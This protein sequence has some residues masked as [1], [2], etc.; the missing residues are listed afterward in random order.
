MA[1]AARRA[2]LASIPNATNSPHRLLTNS[3]SKRP[4]HQANVSQQENEHPHKRLAVDRADNGPA[5][6][7]RPTA[8]GQVFERGNGTIGS[9]AFQKRLVAARE[10]TSMR[11]TKNVESNS[12]EDSIRQWQKHYRRLF[13][14][15]SFYFDSVGDDA[16]ARFVRH[17]SAL[18]AKEEK[19]FSKSVTH[20]ITTRSI[21]SE[22]VSS[23]ASASSGQDD[24]LQT[25]NPSLLDKTIRQRRENVNVDILH[26]GRQMGMKIWAAEKLQR[27]LTSI[28]DDGSSQTSRAPATRP[29]EELSQALRKDKI[30]ASER[31]QPSQLRDLVPFKGPYIY[32]HDM[33]EKYRPTMV[34]EYKPA[35]RGEGEWPQFR[36]AAVGKCPF[37][38]DPGYK[39]RET[40]QD[41]AR[42]AAQ[43]RRTQEMQPP[44]R[45]S[46]RKALREVHHNPAPTPATINPAHL[47]KRA[48][49]N[50]S[51]PP[52]PQQS[53]D[54]LR[55]PGSLLSMS[56]E[57]AASGIQPSKMTSA[58]Q[59]NMIS[60]TAATGVKST[61][62]KEVH[63]LKR[64]VLERTN[65]GSLSVGS[66]PSSHRMNDLAGT[67]KNARA[68]PPTRAAKSKAQEKL[69]VVEEDDDESMQPKM[70]QSNNKKKSMQRDPKPGYCENC[71]D[72]YDDFEEHILS[73]KHR[74]FATT[75]S[76]WEEL[77]ALLAKLQ[78]P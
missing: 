26:R 48:D 63:E 45:V 42:R 5:T 55:A 65:T 22:D 60:S 78:Q 69:G 41:R 31:D 39:Q 23:A 53:G 9:T 21:P 49:S 75:Q 46:P 19:F 1:S 34:R 58:I 32:V 68:P 18:G 28:L 16:R 20:I 15:Y 56:R 10:K 33:D 17:I 50:L 44:R 77:D 13:P 66:I 67:L 43:Q 8:E 52:M 70:K 76:N 74:K 73:R 11:V 40:E 4:R 37:V 36:S 12:K 2:P 62:S 72:K 24:Q 35:R 29:Q 38:E 54:F 6:P 59:S 57:P 47:H 71:R 61:T 51:F 14:T 30:A 3:G 25:I 27:V 64:K 7:A